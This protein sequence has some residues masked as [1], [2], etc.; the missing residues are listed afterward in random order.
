MQGGFGTDSAALNVSLAEAV[1]DRTGSPEHHAAPP[2]YDASFGNILIT[3]TGFVVET[4]E[5][6]RIKLAISLLT[7]MVSGLIVGLVLL[8]FGQATPTTT[9]KEID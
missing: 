6:G 8:R 4:L 9:N 2:T 1:E 7:Q 3:A 5:K